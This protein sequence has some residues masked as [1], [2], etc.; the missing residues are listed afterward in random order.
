MW[1]RDADRSGAVPEPVEVS[2]RYSNHADQGTRIAGVLDS[3][4][5]TPRRP[6][7]STIRHVNRRMRPDEV[8][9]LREAYLAGASTYQ[10]AV[11]LGSQRHTIAAE[12]KRS[13]VERRRRPLCREEVEQAAD[14]YASGLSL[15]DVAARIGRHRTG[16]ANALR[17]A[18]VQLRPRRGWT[19]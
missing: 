1:K 13:G 3:V 18:G 17:N 12:L 6:E 19:Y 11:D 9:S 2:G 10:L 8:A 5:S 16:V 14:L 7:T 15:V 4:P